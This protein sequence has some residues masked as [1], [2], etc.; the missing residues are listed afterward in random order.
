MDLSYHMTNMST[1]T[2]T[3]EKVIK[4]EYGADFPNCFVCICPGDL[5]HLWIEA[6][7][8]IERYPSF[9]SEMNSHILSRI[10]GISY[11][12]DLVVADAKLMEITDSHA[13][14][15]SDKLINTTLKVSLKY[16][17]RL[18]E[19][20][21]DRKVYTLHAI[22]PKSADADDDEGLA[23]ILT[24]EQMTMYED[25][26]EHYRHLES[27]VEIKSKLNISSTPKEVL[28]KFTQDL[29]DARYH[30]RFAYENSFK[31]FK[32][33]SAIHQNIRNLLRA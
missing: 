26:D 16:S 3:L 13:S 17:R 11:I 18:P 5:D 28:E 1:I 31:Y 14:Y 2:S 22:S 7:I 15:Y 6:I 23:K 29:N 9:I 25:L 19:D 33:G 20:S 8:P 32:L 30:L 4:Q 24:Q 27:L 21:S 10:I 12:H